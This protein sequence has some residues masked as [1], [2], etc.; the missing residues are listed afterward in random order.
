[1][2]LVYFLVTVLLF[3][4][5]NAD[6]QSSYGKLGQKSLMDGQFK[7]AVGYFQKA[8][9]E[10]STNVNTLYLLG[11][12][13]YHA[14]DYRNAINAFD[15]LILRKPQET[16]AYYYRGKAKNLLATEI[17]DLKS[18]EK[19]KLLTGSI[20]DYTKGLS[21]APADYKFYQNRGIA[22]RD[23][24]YFKSQKLPKIYDKAKATSLVT[25]SINDFQKVLDKD[26]NRK[27]I[28]TQLEKSKQLLSNIK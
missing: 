27:D 26:A 19:E 28:L 25:A 5:L 15:K 6:A 2:R 4:S 21:I 16:V 8:F 3:F 13:Y 11:Y 24:A 1:M 18:T 7:E 12:S 23:Y 14:A 20:S 17:T 9:Q 10:D 22:Y